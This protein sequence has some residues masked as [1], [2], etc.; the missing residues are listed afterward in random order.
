MKT[1]TIATVMAWLMATMAVGATEV[2][3]TVEKVIGILEEKTVI[4]EVETPV[5]QVDLDAGTWE[6]SVSLNCFIRGRSGATVYMAGG[7]SRYVP[8]MTPHDGETAFVGV[9]IWNGR[10]DPVVPSV[11]RSIVINTP[12]GT[13]RPVFAMLWV[14]QTTFD[15]REAK[16][17][18]FMHARRTR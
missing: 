12:P 1:K 5:M 4:P 16:A 18:G 13:T 6:V 17:Y 11:G 9:A 10:A 7:V 8:T 14:H 3:E 2:G 15:I